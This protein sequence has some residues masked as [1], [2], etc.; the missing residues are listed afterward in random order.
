M[1]VILNFASRYIA[2]PQN[3]PIEDIN[4]F[5]ML[6]QTG[7]S[8]TTF[9]K[10]LRDESGNTVPDQKDSLNAIYLI[11]NKLNDLPAWFFLDNPAVKVIN[12][13]TPGRE[14]REAFIRGGNNFASFFGSMSLKL[15][16]T[17][18]RKTRS[19]LLIFR[20][21]SSAPR[22]SFPLPILIRFVS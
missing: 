20:I 8:S 18:K 10:R 7:L 5:T 22:I 16:S 21:N 11:V 14:E 12:I 19:C 17:E 9:R 3:L 2:G 13:T 1:A 15:I 6:Q 4:A